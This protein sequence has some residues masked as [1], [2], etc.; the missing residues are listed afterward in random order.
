MARSLEA[1]SCR[2]GT[3]DSLRSLDAAEFSI[4]MRKSM[5]D[6]SNDERELRVLIAKTTGRDA[7]NVGPETD[8]IDELG[9]DSLDGLRVLAAVEKRFQVRFLD[10]QLHSYRRLVDILEFVR[11]HRGEE[12]S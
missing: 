11:L 1:D 8:L 4:P 10:H 3:E 12:D 2:E 5:Q 6:P 7:T 9:L